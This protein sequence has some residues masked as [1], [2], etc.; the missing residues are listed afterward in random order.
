[1][2]RALTTALLSVGVAQLAKVP[3]AYQQTGRLDWSNLLRTGGMPSSHSAGVAALA[4]YVA[5]KRGVTSIHF[6][7]ASMLGLI[8]MFDAM[9]IRRQA[10]IIA[11]EVND[12]GDTV[13][14]MAEK[15]PSL[16]HEKR[17]KQ[18]EERLGHIPQEVLG[19]ALMGTF[20]G[21][22][23]F[24]LEKPTRKRKFFIPWFG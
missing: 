6:A 7:T 12:L 11:T 10:G 18:L 9:G 13:A 15:D 22:G 21:A 2:N 1:M 19:G 24:L 20:I 14:L 8:V 16:G 4:S 23:S 5:L 17:E 3:L